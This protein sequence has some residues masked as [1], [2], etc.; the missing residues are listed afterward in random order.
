MKLLRFYLCLL[1]ILIQAIFASSFSNRKDASLSIPKESS[2]SKLKK[3]VGKRVKQKKSP[4][5]KK[6]Q[7]EKLIKKK[8]VRKNSKSVAVV[9]ED[10]PMLLIE[11]LPK[12]L[13]KLVID[14]FIDI[15]F[16]SILVSTHNWA[17]KGRPIIAV[18]NARLYV[19]AESE[20]LSGLDHSL[21]NMKEDKRRLIEFGG[22]QW[23]NYWRFSSS[24]DGRC[25][26]FNHLDKTLIDS[27]GQ[28]KRCT[29]WFTQSSDREDGRLKRVTFDDEDSKWGVL[30]R[31]GQTL[32]SCSSRTNLITRVYRLRVEAGKDPFGLM[33]FELNGAARAVSSKGNRVIVENSGQ[34]EIHD[35]GKDVCE[36]ICRIDMTDDIDVWALNEDGSEAAFVTANMNKEFQI[37]KVDKVSGSAMEQS[38]IVKV[39]VPD[40]LGR[41]DQLVYD[42]TGKPHALHGGGKVS[43]FDPSTKEFI[44]LEAPEEGQKIIR[45]EISPNTDY[46]AFLRDTGKREN[47]KTIYETIVKRKFKDSDW[48]DLFGYEADKNK[49]AKPEGKEQ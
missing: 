33:K 34:L 23:S 19:I 37:V 1:V 16:Y 39:E 47:G 11:M 8:G 36:L 26:S 4:K 29:K 18:D 31:D 14:Y 44:L 2:A 30:S 43:L 13:V 45:L 7:G 21:A 46:I 10:K 42:G 17:L 6:P 24:H 20:G 25:I 22:P 9:K 5:G 38:A 3:V 12:T 28:P 41:I 32:C 15:N 48:K 35:V 40:S 27:S 49:A